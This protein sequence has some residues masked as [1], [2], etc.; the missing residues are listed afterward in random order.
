[1]Q[2]T[3]TLAEGLRR[4][5][6]VVVPASDLE[7]KVDTRLDELK[8]QVRIRGFRPGKVPVEHL[9][10]LYGRAARA[11]AIEATMQE[12]NAKIVT[13]HGFR[14]AAQPK[15]TFPAQ[16]ADVKEVV[17]GKRDLAYSLAIEVL[18]KIDLT[19]FKGIK[20]DRPV[21][22][23][24]DEEVN[25]SIQQIAKQNRPF[26]VKA[27]GATAEQGDRVVV[28]FTGKIDGKPFEGGAAKDIA[29]EIGSNSFLPGFENQ[30]VGM[31]A[32]ENRTVS[33]TFPQNY[34][35]A[36]LAGKEAVFDVTATSIES[37]G[38]VSLDDEFAKSLGME[39]LAKL[40]EAVR[41]RLQREH[42]AM[43]RQRLKRSL[44]DELDKRHQFDLPQSLVDEEF[45]SIWTQ[46]CSDLVRQGRTFA[47]EGTS[48][49][50]AKAEYRQIAERRV[51]LGLVLAEIGERNA[52]KVT[53]DELTRAAA[54]RARQFPGQ[55]QQ[56]W[57]YYRK[58]A[59]A[60]AALRAPIFEEKV[61]DF[62]VEL[63]EVSDKPVSREEL[64]RTEEADEVSK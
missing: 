33:L 28:S 26:T 58:N 25:E 40:K 18:P 14:L 9:R 59:G 60:L 52:I 16:E 8:D 15:V 50:S 41:D 39:S 21:T 12:V 29:V 61:V 54:E 51:R 43:T 30:L 24:A 64:Y 20:L 42:G 46:I 38:T 63:A 2:V 47:D 48:E 6:Q 34:L 10:R 36:A 11:Q 44:L 23:V 1:M 56:V 27:A 62:I 31:A 35:Q 32:G 19:D 53:D 17:E 57:E 5:Y 13:D 3:E 4:E 22:A 55:E 49:E 45:N 37:P 7:A